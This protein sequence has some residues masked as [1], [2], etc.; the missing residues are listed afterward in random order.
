[1][2]EEWG[3]MGLGHVELAMVQ[4]E[5]AR[6]LRTMGFNCQAPD[7][8]TCT[9]SSTGLLQSKRKNTSNLSAMGRHGRVFRYDRT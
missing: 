1:M 8:E 5:A 9:R 4:A 2:P 7:E 3:G 6:V